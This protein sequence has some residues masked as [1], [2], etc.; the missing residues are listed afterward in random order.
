MQDW[1][2]DQQCCRLN[3]DW[4]LNQITWLTE[5]FCRWRKSSKYKKLESHCHH[6]CQLSFLLHWWLTTIHN[7]NTPSVLYVLNSNMLTFS[8]TVL[9][10]ISLWSESQFNTVISFDLQ[11]KVDQLCVFRLTFLQLQTQLFCFSTGWKLK[12]SLYSWSA[13][14]ISGLKDRIQWSIQM[15]V[16][17]ICTFTLC[18]LWAAD[19]RHD[20]QLTPIIKSTGSAALIVPKVWKHLII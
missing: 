12:E 8:S 6:R 5:C 16:D 20:T 15:G 7:L 3:R 13:A 19:M 17:Y 1:T 9:W 4:Q 10:F 2:S 18:L 14:V 11:M